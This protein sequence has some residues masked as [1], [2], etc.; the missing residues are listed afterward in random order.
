MLKTSHLGEVDQVE[1]NVESEQ[2]VGFRRRTVE[3]VR[4]ARHDATF[5][6]SVPVETSLAVLR[7]RLTVVHRILYIVT[8][9]LM[10]ET[11][12]PFFIAYQ[13]LTGRGC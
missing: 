2:Q 9:T 4:D 5:E 1:E 10:L 3:Q 12:G 13:N 8:F 11:R 6:C 7:R